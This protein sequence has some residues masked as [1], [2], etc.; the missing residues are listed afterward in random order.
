MSFENTVEEM[1]LEENGA[2]LSSLKHRLGGEINKRPREVL[3]FSLTQIRQYLEKNPNVDIL[4]WSNESLMNQH[5]WIWGL[6]EGLE[7]LTRLKV[8][9]G[10]RDPSNW[11]VSAYFQ[12][13]GNSDFKD[14][15][16]GRSLANPGKKWEKVSDEFRLLDIDGEPNI[17]KAFSAMIGYMPPKNQLALRQN[18]TIDKGQFSKEKSLRYS[19]LLTSDKILRGWV[20]RESSGIRD[21]KG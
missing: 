10:V 19:D 12:W 20:E 1:A 13:G 11:I 15:A 4:V 9:Y 14:F 8:I 6:K 7:E 21:L 2:E 5:N 18:R 3:E 17:I 16:V